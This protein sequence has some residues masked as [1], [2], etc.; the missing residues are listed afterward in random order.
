LIVGGAD[1]GGVVPPGEV[2]QQCGDGV[3]IGSVEPGG[4]FIDQQDVG[5]GDECAGDGDALTLACGESI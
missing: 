2:L 5:L 4:G 3:G 1:D